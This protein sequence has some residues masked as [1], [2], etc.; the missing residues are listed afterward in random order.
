MRPEIL[1][2]AGNEEALMSAIKAGCDAVYFALPNFG[3]RAYAQNF[4]LEK[5]KE[6]IEYCHLHDVKVYI[7]MNTVMFEDEME[8]AY[9]CAK[10]LHEMNVDALIIQDLGFIHYLHHRLPNLELHASTQLSTSNP[11]MIEQLKKIGVKRVVLAR[12]CTIEEIEACAKTGMEIEVFVH[13]ALCIC[14][15]GQCY[16]SSLRYNRSGNRGMCAQPCRMPYTLMEDGKEVKCDGDYL[17][18]PKDLSLIQKVTELSRAGV[19][20]LKIE[21]R[22]KS[23]EYVYQSVSLVKKA[24]DKQKIT[25]KDFERLNVAFNRGHTYGHTYKDYGKNLMNYSS[26][27]HQGIDIGKVI[28][29]KNKRI[30]VLLDKELNQNDGIRF[31]TNNQQEGCRVNF[32]YDEKG[33]LVNH[34]DAKKVC[35]LD[36]LP[37][38]K[39]GSVVKKTID[40]KYEEEMNRILKE[41]SRQVPIDIQ[42]T[43]YGVGDTLECIASDGKHTVTC[44]STH[45]ATRAMNRETDEEVLRK[46]FSKTKDSWGYFRS[47]MFDLEPEIYF[48]ISDMN[49]LRRDVLDR[50]EQKRIQV[51]SIV[52]KEYDFTCEPIDHVENIMEVQT[53]NQICAFDGMVISELVPFTKKKGNITEVDGDVLAHLGNGKIIDSNMNVTNSYAVAALLEMG[54]ENVVVSDECSFESLEKMMKAF[55]NRYGF[56]APVIKTVYQKRRLMTMNYCPVNTVLKDGS[57]QNCGLCHSHRYELISKDKTASLCLGD[58][59]CHMRL[60]DERAEDL[61]DLIPSYK[62]IGIKGYKIIFVDETS[63]EINV[64]LSKYGNLKG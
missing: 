11:V 18:S 27:N 34:V 51:P 53:K 1:A 36:V 5:T 47:M 19:C 37:N 10:A 33:R 4:T 56:D 63:D 31:V 59:N 35:Q 2:P 55:K 12:E 20:S 38:V 46:Q 64:I 9:E 48:S 54:Y 50:L 22:M 60:F 17:L 39:V 16:F 14:Y 21:G 43:C 40:F 62:E 7:T 32:L 58:R 13:G 41:N 44:H 6:M 57:R 8:E 15:S 26:S 24:L 61:L 29:I 23:K 52:E 25:P 28:K 42:F 30:H 49:Q 45:V 3:A